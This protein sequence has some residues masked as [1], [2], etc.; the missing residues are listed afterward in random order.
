MKTIF[1]KVKEALLFIFFVELNK[2]FILTIIFRGT[3]TQKNILKK[4]PKIY[5]T[6]IA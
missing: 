2:Y 1:L 4:N 6:H 5:F 3:N